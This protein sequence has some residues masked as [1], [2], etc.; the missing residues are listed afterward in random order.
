ML[1]IFFWNLKYVPFLLVYALKLVILI[2]KTIIFQ[3]C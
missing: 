1:P 3:I 2:S